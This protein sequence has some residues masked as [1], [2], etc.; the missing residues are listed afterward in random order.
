MIPTS[1]TPDA[2]F[3]P[4]RLKRGATQ[5]ERICSILDLAEPILGVNRE[6]GEKGYIRKQGDGWLFIT[7]DPEDLIGFPNNTPLRG[8]P[9]Y[10]W[11][12]GHDGIRRGFLTPA[13][14]EMGKQPVEPPAALIYPG[15]RF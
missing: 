5:Y 12:E 8:R 11:V 10:D 6:A 13:A 7:K 9:R 1:P 14:R 4:E 15:S 2:L 3:V